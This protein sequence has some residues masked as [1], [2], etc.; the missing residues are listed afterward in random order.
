MLILE[1]Y[2]VKLIFRKTDKV[3]LWLILKSLENELKIT[4]I[5]KCHLMGVFRNV[6]R[7]GG[8][9]FFSQKTLT[10]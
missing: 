1:G 4:R 10:N 7:G 8:L 5:L 2:E 9:G 6:L 3:L